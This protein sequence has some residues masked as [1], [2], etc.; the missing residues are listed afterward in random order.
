MEDK[1]KEQREDIKYTKNEDYTKTNDLYGTSTF[2]SNNIYYNCS[3]CSSIIKIKSIDENNIEFKCDKH[4]LKMNI[5]EYINKMRKYNNINI[6]DK[7]C[8]IHKE[9]YFSYCFDCNIHLCK[10]C[11]RLRKHAYH[12]KIYLNEVIPENKILNDIEKNIKENKIKINELK[13]EKRYKENKIK[14]ILDN[15]IN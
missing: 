14:I 3:E 12:Y 10:E 5:K 6:N 9:E 8:N 7:I 2:K 1:I 4:E 11:L 15:N 13:K